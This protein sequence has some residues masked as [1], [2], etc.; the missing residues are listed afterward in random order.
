MSSSSSSSQANQTVEWIVLSSCAAIGLYY[1]FC[2]RRG[3]GKDIELDMY[4][5]ETTR[6]SCESCSI[7]Q[8]AAIASGINRLKGVEDSDYALICDEGNVYEHQVAG[9]T[10]ESNQLNCFI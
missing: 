4:C 3:K 10:D 7:D 1:Y 9:H 5:C 6:S 2:R 8:T